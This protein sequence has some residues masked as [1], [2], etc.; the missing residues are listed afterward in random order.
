M[1]SLAKSCNFASK[2]FGGYQ[3]QLLI[4]YSSNRATP[5]V[6]LSTSKACWESI[7]INNKSYEKGRVALNNRS[8]RTVFLLFKSV[9][10]IPS[11]KSI[12]NKNILTLLIKLKKPKTVILKWTYCNDVL[13]L[14]LLL[15]LQGTY[16]T[17]KG[18]P[19]SLKSIEQF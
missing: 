2:A 14:G 15:M 16:Q 10:N 12:V 4:S 9:L 3:G 7:Q 8:C 19:E 6:G 17:A 1:F 5:V 13:V 18:I 11:F